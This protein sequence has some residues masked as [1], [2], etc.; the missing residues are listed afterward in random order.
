MND[1][2]SQT[3]ISNKIGIRPTGTTIGGAAQKQD[4]TIPMDNA[5]T[6]MTFI[7]YEIGRTVPAKRESSREIRI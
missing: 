1:L 6:M 3:R 2:Q 7:L 5:K 4:V